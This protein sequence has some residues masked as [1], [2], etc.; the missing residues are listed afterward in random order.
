MKLETLKDIKP[1]MHGTMLAEFDL[2]KDKLRQ[3][4][5]KWIKELER[6]VKE[7]DEIEMDWHHH[8]LDWKNQNFE[9]VIMFIQHFFNL[10]EEDLK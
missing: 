6:I 1:Y 5:I 3:E 4:A 7:K 8:F 10:K 9:Q 2:V